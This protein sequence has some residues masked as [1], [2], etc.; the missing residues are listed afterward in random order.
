VT[1]ERA[2]LSKISKTQLRCI[3]ELGI[4]HM[5]VDISVLLYVSDYRVVSDRCQR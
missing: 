3:V 1:D 5:L 4:P 2:T